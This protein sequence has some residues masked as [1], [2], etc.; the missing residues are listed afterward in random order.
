MDRVMCGRVLG[1]RNRLSE[2][3]HDGALVMA[4]TSVFGMII[5]FGTVTISV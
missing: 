2:E 1:D 5:G 3:G 4:L